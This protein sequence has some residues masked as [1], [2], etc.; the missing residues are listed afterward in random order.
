MHICVYECLRVHVDHMVG[1]KNKSSHFDFFIVVDCV[2]KALET[3]L[4][5]YYLVLQ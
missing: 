3:G 4:K 5:Y 2:W 1:N